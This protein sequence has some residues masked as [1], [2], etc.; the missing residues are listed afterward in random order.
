MPVTSLTPIET[1]NL[2]IYDRGPVPWSHAQEAIGTGSIPMEVPCFL[3][4]V[5]PDGRPHAAGIGPIE[6]DGAFYIVS[7]PRTRKSKNLAANPA[8]TLSMRFPDLDLVIEA[9]A[10]R[11]TDAETID[12]AVAAYVEGGWPAARDG[13]AITAPYSAQS[14][15][16]PPW[17][18]YR[19]TPHTAFG[20]STREPMGASRW[21]F[22]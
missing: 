18:L 10:E 7:G 8:C 13:D 19:L 17:Y 14:A 4:T 11:V 21:R 9:T 20:L 1:T 6:L 15:G 12:R 22:G 2:D 5:R 3:G 16:P